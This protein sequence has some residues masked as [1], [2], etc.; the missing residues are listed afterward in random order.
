MF[1]KSL[2]ALAVLGVAA[3]YASAANVTLYGVA[4]LGLMYN[5]SKV[6]TGNTATKTDSSN[7]AS[8][9]APASASRARKNSATA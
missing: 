4:D 8:T 2:A 1:K 7:P 5:H 9:P 3:G 6:E